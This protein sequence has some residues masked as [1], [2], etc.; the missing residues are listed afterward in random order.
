MAIAIRWDNAAIK[1]STENPSGPV[2]RAMRQLA[3]KAVTEMKRRAPVYSGPPRIGP[4]PGHPRQGPPRRSGTLRSS[5]RAFRQPAGN[6]LIG[7]TDQ[8]APGVFLGPMIESGTRPHPI[9]SHGPWPLYSTATGRR[10]G[11]PVYRQGRDVRGRYTSGRVLDHW[12]VNHPGTRPH[13]FIRPAAEALNGTR[14]V[15]H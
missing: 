11:R 15:I 7:P 12:H 8:V 13:P 3:D 10:Y 4:T 5:I 6:Y 1:L 14:I 9:D 2:G